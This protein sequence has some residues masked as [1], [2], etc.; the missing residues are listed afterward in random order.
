[1]C[2]QLRS[3]NVPTYFITHR[4]LPR[5]PEA[6]G[7]TTS[8]VKPSESKSPTTKNLV[9]DSRLLQR[10]SA[11]PGSPGIGLIWC[12]GIESSF[13]HDESARRGTYLLM[14]VNKAAFTVCAVESRK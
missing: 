10:I 9:F 7:A 3:G 2:C 6:A 1:M 4:S 12:Q 14:I 11:H 13:A 8:S 5:E